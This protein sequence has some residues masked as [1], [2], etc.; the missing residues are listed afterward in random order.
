MPAATEVFRI[1]LSAMR[2]KASIRT[3]WR[4]ATPTDIAVQQAASFGKR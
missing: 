4:G 1:V 3:I 2:L